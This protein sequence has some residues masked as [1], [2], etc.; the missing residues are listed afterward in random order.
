MS[1]GDERLALQSAADSP[2]EV[3]EPA[4][5]SIRPVHS[6][7][8]RQQYDRKGYP[9]NPASRALARQ[10]R[11]A[12]NDILTTVGVCVG[13]DAEGELRPIPDGSTS[14]LDK[15][16]IAGVIRENEIGMLVGFME[17]TLDVLAGVY[18]LG[19]RCRIQVCG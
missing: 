12:I 7:P 10:S 8:Y 6:E 14:V 3:I 2:E 19:L 4:A 15:V 5:N 9:E 1:A 17:S 18:T 16:K 13:V 11:R